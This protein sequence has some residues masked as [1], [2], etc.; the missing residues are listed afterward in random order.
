MSDTAPDERIWDLL[1]GALATRT[2]GVVAGLRIPEALA[3]V[4]DRGTVDRKAVE[5]VRFSSHV[6]S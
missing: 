3:D 2:L 4:R 5:G 6:H 1:R